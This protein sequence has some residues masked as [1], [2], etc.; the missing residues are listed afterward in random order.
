M[1]SRS[2]TI[3][4]SALMR[5]VHFFQVHFQLWE[6]QNFSIWG[7]SGCSML[8][9][10]DDFCSINFKA[11]L[12]PF[13]LFVAACLKH[14]TCLTCFAQLHTCKLLS[15]SLRVKGWWIRCTNFIHIMH[16]SLETVLTM[17]QSQTVYWNNFI[18]IICL[19]YWVNLKTNAQ[20][21]C[22]H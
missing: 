14:S 21:D 8:I 22:V 5:E 1:S 9:M 10:P 3:E 19:N 13:C 12:V 2:S 4:K 15:L 17:K 16:E 18:K 20:H 11:W 7:V 6:K